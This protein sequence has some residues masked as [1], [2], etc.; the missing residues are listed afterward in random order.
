LQTLSIHIC[1]RIDLEIYPLLTVGVSLL[2]NFVVDVTALAGSR[3]SN[4]F[5]FAIVWVAAAIEIRGLP[6][7]VPV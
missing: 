6:T 4:P 1:K 2:G 5:A 3:R 7:Y